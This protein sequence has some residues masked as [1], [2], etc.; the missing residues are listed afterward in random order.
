[1]NLSYTY[2]AGEF[3]RGMVNMRDPMA[4]A[5]A[6]AVKQATQQ[7]WRKGQTNIASAGLGQRWVKSFKHR[8]YANNGIDAAG[9]VY[10]TINFSVVFERGATIH[11]APIL[12]IPLQT[13]PKKLGS[14]RMTAKRFGE[15]I[16]HL[17][18]IQIN[19][20]PYLAAKIFVS[21]R[22]AAGPVPIMSAT[23][24]RNAA[25]RKGGKGMKARLLPLFVGVSSTHIRDRLRIREI[26]EEASN[27]IPR[28][29]AEHLKAD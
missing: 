22:V 16:A 10:S 23:T 13:T 25:R 18:K 26:V 17:F 15:Q 14:K 4:V 8:F 12:W 9:I 2:P 3:F 28:F 21:K 27:D 19:G 5:G 6:A 24:L 20:K 29:Y 1:M 11:G 7:A